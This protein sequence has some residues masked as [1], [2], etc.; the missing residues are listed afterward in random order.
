MKDLK[1]DHR[2]EKEQIV[3]Y[4][5]Y[6][7][8]QIYYSLV[9]ILVIWP[10][11]LITVRVLIFLVSHIQIDDFQQQLSE[12]EQKLSQKTHEVEIMQSELKLV[13]EF[14]RKRAQMQKELEEVKLRFL[15]SLNALFKTQR[16]PVLEL[17][18]SRPFTN[19]YS[20]PFHTLNLCSILYIL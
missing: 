7:V 3:R 11:V 13:K 6:C 19:T 4:N 1:K 5:T 12:V 2:K 8:W 14:R 10:S 9:H 17:W 18:A 15:R 20:A 16:E